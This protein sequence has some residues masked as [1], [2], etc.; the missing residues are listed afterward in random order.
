LKPRCAEP[1]LLIFPNTLAWKSLGARVKTARGP[2][3]TGLHCETSPGFATGASFLADRPRPL[4]SFCHAN[5]HCRSRLYGN[6]PL[7]KS[8][9][10]SPGPHSSQ[11]ARAGASNFPDRGCQL[12][13]LWRLRHNTGQISPTAEPKDCPA[14]L[15]QAPPLD[16]A[17]QHRHRCSTARGYSGGSRAPACA[18][19][20][21]P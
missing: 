18:W 4:K 19:W 20:P 14:K 9:A 2:A 12:K 6:Q 21:S 17:R 5:L 8:R 15:P 3:L 1:G 16:Q 7:H 11:L 10:V 13:S